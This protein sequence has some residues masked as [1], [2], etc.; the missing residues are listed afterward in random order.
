MPAS[1]PGVRGEGAAVEA[2]RPGALVL[3]SASPRRRELLE[4]AG[5]PH[6]VV[7]ADID[8]ESLP[9]E[10]AREMTRRLAREKALA[11]AR[12]L[13]GG[14]PRHV[15]GSDTTVALDGRVF[16]KPSDADDAL[17]LLRALAGRTHLV[18]TAIAVVDTRSLAVFERVV[19]SRV[20]MRSAG[21]DE[22]RAYVATGEPL[23]KAG[24][25]AIQGGGAALVCRLEGSRTNV[26]GL[27]VE[28]TLELLSRAGFRLGDAGAPA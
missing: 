28:E 6:E 19:E 5:V 24:A 4:Q 16:G 26:I 9:G 27:P 14:T 2:D 21:D 12:R 7:P 15:L 17:R 11:V 1:A 20:S 8:E 18:I 22:L 13:A 25:Y 23:D 3:A 10:S